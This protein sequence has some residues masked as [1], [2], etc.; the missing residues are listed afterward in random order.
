W[1]VMRLKRRLLDQEFESET[2]PFRRHPM[3]ILNDVSRPLQKLRGAPQH[4]SI[5]TRSVGYR[6]NKR[7]AE[8]LVGDL[9]AERIK[10][11]QFFR[12]RLASRHHV[13]VLE[14][15]MG[16]QVRTVHNCLVGP[17]E[18]ESAAHR[19]ADLRIPEFFPP[20]VNE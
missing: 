4:A 2:F 16:A 7:L 13:G 20:R 6:R 18:I 10:K 19:L 1:H 9:A 5:L 11:R 17:F 3:A 8:H 14:Y 12:R 15:R